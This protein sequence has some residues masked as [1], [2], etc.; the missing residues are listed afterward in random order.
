MAFS[1]VMEHIARAFEF[2]AA[3]VLIVGLIWSL[4]YTGKVWWHTKDGRRAYRTLRI[5]FG[6]VLLLG[7]EILV[8]AD[9]LLSVVVGPSLQGVVVLGLVVLTR[10]VLSFSL[11]TEIEGVAPW[12]RAAVLRRAPDPPAP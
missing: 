10:T 2:L 5:S 6:A 11:E 4:A 12:K 9:L 3:V 8:A 7:L 1:E